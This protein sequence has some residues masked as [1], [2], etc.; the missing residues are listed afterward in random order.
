MA[1]LWK[2]TSEANKYCLWKLSGFIFRLFILSFPPGDDTVFPWPLTLAL[3]FPVN[4][5]PHNIIQ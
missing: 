4:N 1:S 2:E 5:F 3:P